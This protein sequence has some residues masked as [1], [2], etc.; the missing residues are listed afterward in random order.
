M[1]LL[2]SVAGLEASYGASQVLFGID[3]EIDAGEAVAL[4]G[5]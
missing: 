1:K 2:L 4:L 5:R 3:L